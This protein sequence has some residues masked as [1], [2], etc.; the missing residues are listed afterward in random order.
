VCEPGKAAHKQGHP[1]A[2]SQYLRDVAAQPGPKIVDVQDLYKPRVFGSYWGKFDA[3]THR[4]LG[5]VGT[6]TDGTVRDWDDTCAAG[7]KTLARRFCVGHAHRWPM[8]WNREVEVF[9]ARSAHP[10]RQAWIPR[11]PA[12]RRGPIAGRRALHGFEPVPDRDPG[13]A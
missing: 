6:V 2:V 4:A 8:R 13:S 10:C 11:H 1:D 9:A 7:F 3:N 12:G 5:C